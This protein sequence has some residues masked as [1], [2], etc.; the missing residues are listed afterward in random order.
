MA[1][2]LG[3]RFTKA[4]RAQIFTI[5]GRVLSTVTFM[6]GYNDEN[7]CQKSL[8][9]IARTFNDSDTWKLRHKGAVN[10]EPALKVNARFIRPFHF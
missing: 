7:K 9:R 8:A 6:A 5:K 1:A 2:A 4:D 3:R 10:G